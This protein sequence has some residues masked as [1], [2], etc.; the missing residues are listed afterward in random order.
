MNQPITQIEPTSNN[1]KSKRTLY[2]GLELPLEL[3]CES[4]THC[5]LIKIVPRSREDFDIAHMF[6][7]LKKFTHIIFTSKSAVKVFVEYAALFGINLEELNQKIFISVGK[8]TAQQLNHSGITEVI[9]ASIETAEGIVDLLTTLNLKK[10]YILWPHSAL[11]RPVILD[12][13]KANSIQFY[14]CV[15]YDTFINIPEHLPDIEGY[16]EIIFTSPSIVDAFFSLYGMLP[17]GK[18]ITCIGP[19]TQKAYVNK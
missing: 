5:P 16:D 4:V 15:I 6:A 19:V 7:S 17:E 1:S 8:K 18:K 12:W 2:L 9:T 11:S 13:L 14:E 3:Q 10:S